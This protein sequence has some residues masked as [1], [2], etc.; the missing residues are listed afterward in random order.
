MADE[1]NY[2]ALVASS[3]NAQVLA[4]AAYFLG[5][6]ENELGQWVLDS[7]ENAEVMTVL[8]SGPIQALDGEIAK[9][10]RTTARAYRSSGPPAPKAFIPSDVV[11]AYMREEASDVLDAV[12]A[13]EKFRNRFL[14]VLDE[15]IR[16]T[17]DHFLANGAVDADG[18]E[19]DE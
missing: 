17:Q 11:Y 14:S 4:Y 12:G 6:A 15:V 19:V 8:R 2:V 5:G 3:D 16:G 9:P 18:G 10:I 13:G 7:T 1:P